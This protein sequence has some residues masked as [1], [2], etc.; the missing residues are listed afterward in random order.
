WNQRDPILKLPSRRAAAIPAGETDV[1]LPDG[2]V[3]QFRFA[4]EFCNVA[5]PAGAARNQ[6]PD[7]L[8]G[9]FGPR[10]GLPG[11]A[12]PVRFRASPEGLWVEPVATEARDGGAGAGAEIIDLASRR[13]VVAYPDVRAAAGHLETAVE[14]PDAE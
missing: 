11:P 4:R 12:F 13:R 7:L 14:E 6:L 3:W 2:S 5:R 8:R 9:W 10:A 1:R